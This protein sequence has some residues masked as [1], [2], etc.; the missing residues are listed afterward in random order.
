M[1][2]PLSCHLP[3]LLII[4]AVIFIFAVVKF[5]C[6]NQCLST[7][8]NKCLFHSPIQKVCLFGLLS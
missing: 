2:F 5:P 8:Q 4:L 6:Y 7:K 3:L 1:S